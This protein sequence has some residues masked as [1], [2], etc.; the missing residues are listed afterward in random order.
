MKVRFKVWLEKGGETIISE[1]KYHLLKEIERS[2]SIL[3][4]SQKLGLTYKRAYSQL[5][6]MEERLGTKLV[7]RRRKKGATLTA[8]GKRLLEL[9]E[10][11]LSGFR[12]L[13]AS[14]ERELS[15]ERK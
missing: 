11:V 6:V 9:Y 13:S 3:R 1:G 5:K 15:E 14:L 8:E 7:D 12:E 4:A 10:R 2:G